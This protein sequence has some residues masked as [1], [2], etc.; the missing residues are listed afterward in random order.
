MNWKYTD[1]TNTVAYRVLADGSVQS[2]LVSA[3]SNGTPDPADPPTP[4]QIAVATKTIKDA[5][6]AAAANGDALVVLVA[7]LT[8]AQVDT[9][10]DNRFPAL[11]SLQRDVLKGYGKVLCVLARRL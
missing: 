2:C 9:L 7:G 4:A 6:D 10:I 5:A 3:I 1:A 11:T 8:P